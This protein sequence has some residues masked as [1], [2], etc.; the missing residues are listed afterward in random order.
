MVLLKLFVLCSLITLPFAAPTLLQAENQQ[1]R[2][3]NRAL[4]KA[5]K[6]SLTDT[7]NAVGQEKA[8]FDKTG[9]DPDSCDWANPAGGDNLDFATCK[10]K[11][12]LDDNCYGIQH[13]PGN[14]DFVTQSNC[15]WTQK[16][17]GSGSSWRV[18]SKNCWPKLKTPWDDK[19]YV[20]GESGDWCA[21]RVGDIIR[22]EEECKYAA[23]RVR[24]SSRN[25]ND[26]WYKAVSRSFVGGCSIDGGNTHFNTNFERQYGRESGKPVCIARCIETGGGKALGESCTKDDECEP[27][28]DDAFDITCDFHWDF[29]N[30]KLSEQK[31]CGRVWTKRDIFNRPFM[32]YTQW[33]AKPQNALKDGFENVMDALDFF[34]DNNNE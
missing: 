3:T 31:V 2:K 23:N 16:Y 22:S 13:A 12:Q 33:N 9:V 20:L 30:S 14:C 8:C 6:A 10:Y 5:L 34:N 19:C 32:E 26:G 7:E 15:Q 1:L 21:P 18:V 27:E 29:I 24:E 28:P 11:C 25:P 17:S 4:L